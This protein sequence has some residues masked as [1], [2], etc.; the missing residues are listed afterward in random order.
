MAA[1]SEMDNV[2]V[3]E[4]SHWHEI[5]TAAQDPELKP[6]DFV[7]LI[8]TEM[9]LASRELQSAS[10]H[11]IASVQDQTTPG[12]NSGTAINGRNRTEHS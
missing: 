4:G 8:L 5:I 1:T 2:V 11:S 9:S 3:R 7:R 12:R 10:E 6:A